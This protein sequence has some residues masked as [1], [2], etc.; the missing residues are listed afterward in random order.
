MDVGDDGVRRCGVG[1]ARQENGELVAAE[2]GDQ[3]A[4]A[5]R[6]RQAPRDFPQERIAR[7]VSERVVDVLE[8]VEVEHQHGAHSAV[9]AAP[10]R[11]LVAQ[12]LDEDAAVG[13]S[14]EGVL[15][16][17][18]FDRGFRLFEARDVRAHPHGVAGL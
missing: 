9:L 11:Q 1:D 15:L 6:P 13:E 5:H 3:V 8:M 2:A 12:F 18:P 16:R 14:R 7:I 4:A 10:L 17:V